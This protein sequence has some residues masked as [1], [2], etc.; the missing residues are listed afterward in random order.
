MIANGVIARVSKDFP[1]LLLYRLRNVPLNTGNVRPIPARTVRNRAIYEEDGRRI[2]A[3]P[4][5]GGTT[6]GCRGPDA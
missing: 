6:P 5:A 3:L 4:N 1:S 2:F